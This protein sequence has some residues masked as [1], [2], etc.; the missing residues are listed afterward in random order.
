MKWTSVL[1]YGGAWVL[2]TAVLLALLYRGGMFRDGLPAALP[3]GLAI[4][5]FTAFMFDILLGTRPRAL[6]KNS[7]IKLLYNFHAVIALIGILA[8]AYHFYRMYDWGDPIM[9]FPF[10]T[11]VPA[12]LLFLLAVLTGIFVLSTTFVQYSSYL[13]G[14][15]EKKFKRENSLFLHRL[16]LIGFILIYFHAVSFGFVQNNTLFAVV[17]TI[18]FAFTLIVYYFYKLRILKLPKYK[19][20]AIQNL[21]QHICRIEMVP[22]RGDIMT[23]RPG[24]FLFFRPVGTALP[25]EAHP[26]SMTSSP[27]QK[28]YISI[29]VKESGDFTDQISKLKVD[30]LVTL[31]GPYGNLFSEEL[32]QKE[33][34]LVM[35]AGGIGITPMISILSCLLENHSQRDIVLFWSA[36]TYSDVFAEDFY[37]SLNNQHS[38]FQLQILLSKEER[39]GF[40]Y[41]RIS[42]EQF[43]KTNMTHHYEK[44]DF[45]VCGPPK[46]LESMVDMLKEQKVDSARIHAEEFA[47]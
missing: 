4:V 44:A 24:E 47:F 25:Y 17:F 42:H 34:A 37:R 43:Q 46:M 15:K 40:L 3:I 36:S 6:E 20:T 22:T 27:Q 39:D 18:Y 41:G 11:G 32:E 31:E 21:T 5:A 13:T 7:G 2:L 16:V 28:E 45:L 19:V 9:T 26:F 38:N 14:L 1:I 8:A 33:T 23:Y 35:L 29:L 10:L 30:D 12:F